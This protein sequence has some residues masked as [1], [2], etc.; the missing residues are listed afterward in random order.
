MGSEV[1]ILVQVAGHEDVTVLLDRAVRRLERLELTWSRFL[2]DSEL[3]RLNRAGTPTVVG[4]DTMQLVERC[5]DAWAGTGGRFDPT[6]GPAL[7]AAGYDRTFDE[8]VATDD[9]QLSATGPPS[10]PGCG[11]IGLVAELGVVHLPVGVSIDP[12]G[13]GKGLA[14]DIV[15]GELVGSGADGALVSVGGDLR[16]SG[17]APGGAWEVELDHGTAATNASGTGAVGR[18]GLAEG[19]IATSS[20]LR[21][22][23]RS[24]GGTAH[25]VIDP[26][27]GR[28]TA[29]AALACT[30]IAG[31]AWWAEALA[32]AVLVAWEE[33]DGL[34]VAA[35][36]LGED[37]AAV[38]TVADGE[39]V[40]IGS[41]VLVA[42][43]E[44]AS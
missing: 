9:R 42:P 10:I 28:P 44:V 23:W 43:M 22:R 21:R 30:V 8:L 15:A 18:I 31:E 14:A 38:V 19:A 32:T 29:G 16:A 40:R 34:D 4:A 41:D 20:I 37:A 3:S 1:D 17:R 24:S 25:H 12:G 35:A 33:P 26:R 6:T 5:V 39:V 27:T 2:V 7:V 11:G 13:I 36:L